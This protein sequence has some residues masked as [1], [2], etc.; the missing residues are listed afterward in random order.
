MAESANEVHEIR[1]LVQRTNKPALREKIV[2]KIPDHKKG[3]SGQALR[4]AAADAW[5]ADK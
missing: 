1:M 4:D 3:L 5:A 2:A